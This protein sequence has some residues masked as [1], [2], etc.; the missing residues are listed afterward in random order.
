VRAMRRGDRCRERSP[1]WPATL[2]GADIWSRGS[3]EVSYRGGARPP[4]V[5]PPAAEPP[6]G[7]FLQIQELPKSVA[8]AGQAGSWD[9]RPTEWIWALAWQPG[10]PTKFG[11]TVEQL[12]VERNLR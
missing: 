5:R 7:A 9:P 6:R 11:W 10:Q 3:A 4:S 2:I 1:I 12:R 8:P